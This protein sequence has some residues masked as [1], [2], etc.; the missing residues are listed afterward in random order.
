MAGTKAPTPSRRVVRR[1]PAA[2]EAKAAPEP[3]GLSGLRRELALQKVTRI[4]VGG[5]DLDGVFRGKYVSMEKFQSSARGG[6]GFCDVIFGWDSGDVLY[7]NARLTGWHTGY[8]DIGARIDLST[9]RLIPW[10]PGTAA[11]LMDFVTPEGAP[12]PASPRGLMRRMV[13][14]AN[15]MGFAPK[16]S[17]EF[18]YFMFKESPESVREK[19][20]RGL[21]PLS[22][23]MFGY[24]WLRASEHAPLVHAIVDG[25]NAFRI[26]IEGMHTETGPGVY[27]SAIAYDHA[28][29]AA[30]RAALFKTVV[31]EICARHGVM[32]CFMAKWNAALPGCSGHVHQSL[33]DL[34]GEENLFVDPRAKLGMSKAMRHF[35]GGQ[36][37]LMPEITAL[38]SPTVNSYK[39][40]VPGVWA[41]LNATWGLENRTCALRVIGAG[42]NA[43]KALR[44]E[45]RQAAA[46]INPY[47]AM[48][49]MLGAGLWGIEN[50]IEPPPPTGADAGTSGA[51]PL[52]GSLAEAV[53]LLDAS[54]PAREI[55]GDTFV[56]HY[57]RTREWEVRQYERAVTDWELAR[58][59]EI[60]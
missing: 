5:F 16:Y 46:D 7:D 15:S 21:T 19:G 48:A 55:L 28:L 34:D 60:I 40:Y 30:D 18:E 33:W 32:P 59:F 43:G 37:R 23:G 13:E 44:I 58:Y 53:R 4:K 14:R 6:L 22:P 57:L 42:E 17:A 27:E 45:H 24:S 26:P 1:S 8:P 10:E 38:I 12:H 9:Y 25:C 31:K 35:L 56:D 36:L 50:E 29:E 54:K 2:R 11:F 47:V 20:Y 49:A 3:D 41:P 51:P 52:P 39:R